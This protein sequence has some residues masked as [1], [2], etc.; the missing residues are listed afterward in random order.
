MPA[1]SSPE[2]TP[3]DQAARSLGPETPWT[4][5][6]V[7]TAKHVKR[8]SFLIVIIFFRLTPTDSA[9]IGYHGLDLDLPIPTREQI[10]SLWLQ[11]EPDW[12]GLQIR[13]CFLGCKWSAGGGLS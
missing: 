8:Q 5:G 7:D 1:C 10:T 2:R 13:R 4:R 6:E 3:S 9:A 11:R 12:R